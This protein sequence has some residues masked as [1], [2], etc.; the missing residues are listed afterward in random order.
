MVLVGEHRVVR[1][2][3]LLGAFD[4]GVPIGAFDQTAHQAYLV[5]AGQRG[6]VGDQLQR[7]GLIGL[8]SQAKTAPIGV[9]LGHFGHQ[10]LKQLQR[11]LQPIHLFGVHRQV[12]VGGRRALAQ[13]PHAGNQLG[14][15]P[16]AVGIFITRVQ[17][18]QFDGYTIIFL[19]S[20]R[21]ICP[22]RY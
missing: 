12:D 7:A 6:D 15:D 1:Q 20:P 11:Q 2:A 19:H 21:G 3:Q 4:L 18:A 14:H 13:A 16:R 9:V 17:C 10:H 22:S 8:H 5:F